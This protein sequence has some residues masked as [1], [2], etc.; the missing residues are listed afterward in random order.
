MENGARKTRID[1]AWVQA[2]AAVAQLFATVALIGVTVWYV[3]V[4][5]RMARAQVD[6]IVDMEFDPYTKEVVLWNSGV[7]PVVDT[8][9]SADS[10]PMQIWPPIT[11]NRRGGRWL[12][13]EAL[14][15]W[16]T[17]GILAP[18][19]SASHTISDLIEIEN[20]LG[21]RQMATKANPRPSTVITFRATFYRAVDRKRYT[22]LKH[23]VLFIDDQGKA[24]AFQKENLMTR[25]ELNESLPC[26][27]KH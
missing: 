11:V 4:T 25:S 1:P 10:A 2:I 19:Q 9:V 22:T 17:I 18:G 13:R 3:Q 8:W 7:E 23:V 14:A 24:F 27:E 20:R 5:N 15:S 21:T 6:P 16:W 12:P 26:S